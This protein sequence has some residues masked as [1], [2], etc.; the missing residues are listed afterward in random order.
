MFQRICIALALLAVL[1]LPACERRQEAAAGGE[2]APERLKVSTL[3]FLSFGPLFIAQEE[4]YFAE[5]GLEIEFVDLRRT[6]FGVPALVSGQ[7]DVLAAGMT[8]GVL[9]SIARGAD[10]RMVADRCHVGYPG[11]ECTWF[12]ALARPE[13][14]EN[15]VLQPGPKKL[16]IATPLDVVH[17]MM[18]D[19]LLADSGLSRADVDVRFVQYPALPDAMASGTIDVAIV[20]EPWVT[21][22]LDTGRAELWVAGEEVVPGGQI[23]AIC[24]GPRL[25]RE[26]PDIGRRFMV[27]NLKGVRQYNR[28]KTERNLDILARHT[29]QDRELLER[30]C[31]PNMRDDGMLNVD[32]VTDFQSWAAERELLDRRLEPEEFWEPAFVQHAA[33]A[34]GADVTKGESVS[35]GG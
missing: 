7:L 11:Q 10:V 19:R 29:G 14:L 4:G 16:R 13:L 23:G 35:E 34:L 24:Y 27:A 32:S 31:W 25:L 3:P 18:L 5:Q 21:R 12:A 17:G 33:G 2:E 1:L 22:L 9:N 28:G 15:G 6:Q 20:G 26:E 30:L 8:G